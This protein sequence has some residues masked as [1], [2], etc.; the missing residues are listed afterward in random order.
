VSHLLRQFFYFL[1]LRDGVRQLKA[2]HP[3]RHK[4]DVSEFGKTEGWEL[5]A[6]RTGFCLEAQHFPDSP[7]HKKF[8]VDGIA[9]GRILSVDDHLP[10]LD[11]RKIEAEA[12]CC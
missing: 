10:V 5:Y 8:P 4:R 6:H 2:V 7:N 3:G 1:A 9:G 11:A 12:E